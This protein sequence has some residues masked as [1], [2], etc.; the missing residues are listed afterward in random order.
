MFKKSLV[1]MI[2]VIFLVCVST[3]QADAFVVLFP[4]VGLAIVGAVVVLTGI[5]AVVDTHNDIEAAAAE[6][7]E[8]PVEQAM[9][10]IVEAPASGG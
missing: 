3:P 6:A 8:A 2:A 10:E 5:G 7:D 4:A 1:L 9:P